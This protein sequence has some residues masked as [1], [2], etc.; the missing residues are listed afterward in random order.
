MIDAERVEVLLFDLGGVVIE[1]DFGR[2]FAHWARASGRDATELR[3]RFSMDAAYAAHERGTIDA[4][5][6]FSAVRASMELDLSDSDL[7]HGWNDIYVGPIAGVAPLL[8][9]A[10]AVF[11]LHAFTNTNPSHQAVWAHR[12]ANELAVFDRTFVSSELGLRKPD[13]EA[14]DAV[15]TALNASPDRIL[16]FDDST[17]N[18][19]G[20]RAAGLQA[21]LVRSTADVRATLQTLG[22]AAP[23]QR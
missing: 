2:C 12:F 19:A 10:R 4:A 11:P 3:S 9:A 8:A 6:Y 21:V 22:V 18:V 14:F 7:L 1:I 17:E 13:P 23:D 20:A 5:G 15:A 16:F